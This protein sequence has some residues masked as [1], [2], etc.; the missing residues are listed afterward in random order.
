MIGAVRRSGE[1]GE[2]RRLGRRGTEGLRAAGVDPESIE[3]IARR[4]AELTSEAHA[5]TGLVDA[6]AVAK[7]FG[8]A[9]TWVYDHADELGAIPVGSGPRPRLRFDLREVER[10]LTRQA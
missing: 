9:R 8:L 6:S 1:V 3:E 5:A 2:R 7:Y 10:R 4:V